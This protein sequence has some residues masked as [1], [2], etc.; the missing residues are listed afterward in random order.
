MIRIEENLKELVLQ[1]LSFVVDG[2]V[3]KEGMV[4]LYNTKQNFIKF[5]IENDGQEKDWELTYPYK[6]LKQD[7]GYL[8][9]Y[10]LSAFCPRTEDVYWKMFM[11]NRDDSSRLYNN[12]LFVVPLSS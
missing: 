8:F 10:T 5:K 6:I 2:R 11:M 1:K 7:S 9:D 4:K 3:I 12:Y